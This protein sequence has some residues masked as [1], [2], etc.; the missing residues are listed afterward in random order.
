MNQKVKTKNNMKIRTDITVTSLFLLPIFKVPIR[1][2]DEYGFVNSFLY[3]KH[4]TDS[5]EDAKTIY[6]LFHPDT[7]QIILLQKQIEDWENNGFLLGDYDYPDGYVVVMLKF[8]DK[9][10]DQYKLFLK[11]QYSKFSTEFKDAIP[12]KVFTGAI[13]PDGSAAEEDSLQFRI[14]NKRVMLKN[15]WEDQI[16]DEFDAEGEYWSRPDLLKETMDIDA[17]TAE[18]IK[19]EQNDK[20]GI[21]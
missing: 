13:A 20:P 17:I 2:L 21:N 5:L 11:G 10:R 9:F 12:R 1:K 3:D 14:I 4:R 7:S 8:P 16:G 19:K 6:V 18:R 15:Y